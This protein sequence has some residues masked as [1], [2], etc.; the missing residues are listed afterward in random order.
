MPEDAEPRVKESL[1][2]QVT[3]PGK[4]L[5]IGR[6]AQVLLEEARQVGL[7]EPGRQRLLDIHQQA[8]REIGESVSSELRDELERLQPPLGQDGPPGKAELGVAQAQLVGWLDGIGRGI[9][10]GLAIQQ[11]S[12]RRD[13]AALRATQAADRADQARGDGHYL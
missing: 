6:M 5:R 9:Q 12:A 2:G 13:L 11:A 4:L 3:E 7:D 10:T 8:V 1:A